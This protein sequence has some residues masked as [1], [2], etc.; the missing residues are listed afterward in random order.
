MIDAGDPTVI[1]LMILENDLKIHVFLWNRQWQR[2]WQ[3]H[4][5]LKIQL[6]LTCWDIESYKDNSK[7]S[8]SMKDAE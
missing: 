2:Y 3:W 7:K 8:A 4:R 5:D 6:R 1:Q